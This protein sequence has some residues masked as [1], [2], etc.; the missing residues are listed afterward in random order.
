MDLAWF[1]KIC[2]CYT[3]YSFL[4]KL[5]IEDTLFTLKAYDTLISYDVLDYF[6]GNDL[7]SAQNTETH[8]GENG[9]DSLENASSAQV[10]AG[11]VTSADYDPSSENPNSTAGDDASEPDSSDNT[12]AESESFQSSKQTPDNLNTTVEVLSSYS[13]IDTSDMTSQQELPDS[14]LKKK[15]TQNKY[16]FFWRYVD[17]F[18]I[19]GPVIIPAVILIFVIAYMV[20]QAVPTSTL[21]NKKHVKPSIEKPE[22]GKLL[23]LTSKANRL[24]NFLKKSLKNL[25]S[26]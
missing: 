25:F 16:Y 18:D 11:A 9:V 3:E 23:L 19:Y 4:L 1:D 13:Y 8:L 26:H 20:R 15:E 5:Q 10:E 17:H 24:T 6:L 7:T 2:F 21:F 14:S 12:H 22:A